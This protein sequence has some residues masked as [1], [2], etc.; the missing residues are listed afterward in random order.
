MP[1]YKAYLQ[2]YDGDGKT[3]TY[4]YPSKNA[5]ASADMK[6]VMTSFITNGAIFKKVPVTK[7]AAY[8]IA[9]TQSDIDIS[10]E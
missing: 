7:K 10:D 8:I 4:S 5:I 1:N 9:T 6:Q 2:F 3:I